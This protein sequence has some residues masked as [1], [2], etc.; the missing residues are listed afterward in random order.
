VTAPALVARLQRPGP[1]RR[2]WERTYDA[3]YEALRVG[4]SML[5]RSLF[6]VRR[7]EPRARTGKWDAL[8]DETVLL[9]PNHQSY[10]DPAF[11]QLV[12][13]R[14]VLFVMTDSFYRVRT[15]NVF[16][17]L[18]GALPVAKGRMT[19]STMRRAV[20]LLRCGR[21]LVVFPEGRLSTDGELSPAQ[22]GVAV[23]AR[24]ANV[25]VVPVAIE[26]SRFAWPRGAKWLHRADVRLAVGAPLRCTGEPSRD[27]DQAFADRILSEIATLRA[28][29]VG[30]PT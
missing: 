7:L 30:S 11:V 29:I 12:V 8:P 17:R 9:C 19:W 6:R 5:F 1:F 15:A 18:V 20:A 23:I 4:T 13:N 28:R 25:P 3:C 16:F 24:R 14:R 10:L 22:R 27:R 21:S 26:G 2:S